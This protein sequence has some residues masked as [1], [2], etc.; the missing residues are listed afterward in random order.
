MART[1]HG[2]IAVYAPEG[3]LR[4]QFPRA[5]YGG[6]Q[7]YLTL[8]LQDSRDNR[9][10][11]NNLARE[12]EWDRLKGNFDPSL[13]KYHKNTLVPTQILTL[14]TLWLEYCQYKSKNLKAASLYYLSNTLGTHIRRCPHQRV[15]LA[16]NIREW[17]LKS[18]TAGM[19]RRVLSALASATNWGLKHQKISNPVNPFLGMAEEIGIEKDRTQANA[20]SHQEREQIIRAFEANEYYYYYAPLVKF[21]FMTGCRPSEGIGLEWSQ[22][23]DD[24]SS[25]VFDRSITKVGRA[26]VK[27]RRSKNNRKRKFNCQAELQ[28]FLL[29]HRNRR[30][31]RIDLVFPSKEGKPIDY[32]NFSRRAWDKVVDPLINRH[33]T[34]YSCRDTFITDQIGKGV[35]LAVIAKWCDNSVDMIEK[36]YLDISAI[37]HIKP[38]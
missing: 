5:W 22:V 25:I 24:C 4:L 37:S 1:P 13:G 9:L 29:D 27:N 19:A 21:W 8:G 20:F 14:S 15:D 11:A 30:D 2:S 17:L 31:L 16:L 6:K 32:L 10:Y 26:I 34:P 33:S 18:T 28:K 12:I 38:L 7:K 35:S 36:H 23:N 3:R